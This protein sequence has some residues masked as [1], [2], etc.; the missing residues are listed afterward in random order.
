MSASKLGLDFLHGRAAEM[1]TK[2][3]T[4]KW[5]DPSIG[6]GFVIRH[7]EDGDIFFH[8]ADSSAARNGLIEKDMA[9]EFEVGQGRSSKKAKALN[10]RP[11]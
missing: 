9:V 5:F 11:A 8:A 2:S 3:G 7:D 6:Y 10:V 4:V 1:E